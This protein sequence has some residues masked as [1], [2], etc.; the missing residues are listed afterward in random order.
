MEMA[1]VKQS[2]DELKAERKQSRVSFVFRLSLPLNKRWH[3]YIV[4]VAELSKEAGWL[5]RYLL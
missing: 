5:G 3:E 2:V 4:P 1:W